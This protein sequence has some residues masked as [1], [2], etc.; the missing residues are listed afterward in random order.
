MVVANCYPTNLAMQLSRQAYDFSDKKK[1][2]DFSEQQHRTDLLQNIYD[3]TIRYNTTP[4]KCYGK[5]ST[6]DDTLEDKLI[7]EKKLVRILHLQQELED[8]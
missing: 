1:E 3:I 8:T 5:N 4:H 7:Q 2:T 6:R